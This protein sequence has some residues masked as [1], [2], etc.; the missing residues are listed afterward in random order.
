MFLT[1]KN[2]LQWQPPVTGN[3]TEM[4]RIILYMSSEE[5]NWIVMDMMSIPLTQ[6]LVIKV[7]FSHLVTFLNEKVCF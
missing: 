5:K 2:V 1:L 3:Q 7:F 6:I 4:D